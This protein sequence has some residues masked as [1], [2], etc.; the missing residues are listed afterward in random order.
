[1]N[2]TKMVEEAV[3]RMR[4]LNLWDM[5]D[6]SIIRRFAEAGELFKS[7]PARGGRVGEL[8]TLSDAEQRLVEEF[9]QQNKCL[10]YHVIRNEVMMNPMGVNVQYSFLYVSDRE[11]EWE[12]DKSDLSGIESRILY[13][14]AYV[15]S[16]GD[17]I[18]DA[19]DLSG[20]YGEHMII[21]IT[22]GCG[23]L[24]RVS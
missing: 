10:V 4:L 3:K 7:I 13:P 11:D 9:E 17:V 22:W 18:P 20:G 24:C 14:N 5:P 19:E 15:Y 1:M 23:G 16:A 8:F 2:K 12:R 21:G 6:E